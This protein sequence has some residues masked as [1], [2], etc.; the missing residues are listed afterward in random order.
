MSYTNK[1]DVYKHIAEQA[2][3]SD[4]IRFGMSKNDLF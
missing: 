2:I 1:Y 3:L 4:S